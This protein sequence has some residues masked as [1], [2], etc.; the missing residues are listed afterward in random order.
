MLEGI[1]E[2]R[3]VIFMRTHVLGEG[4]GGIILVRGGDETKAGIFD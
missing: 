3:V 2:I 1:P 4:E